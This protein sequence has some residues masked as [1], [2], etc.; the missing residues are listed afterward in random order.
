MR[1]ERMTEHHTAAV[2][3]SERLAWKPSELISSLGL[4]KSTVYD[5]LARGV[6]PSKKVG[7]R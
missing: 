3:A 1:P 2:D 4:S 6:I 7:R 5:A